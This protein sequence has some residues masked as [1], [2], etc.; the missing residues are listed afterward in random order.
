MDLEEYLG[1]FNSAVGAT[2]QV[3][4]NYT[5]GAFLDVVAERLADAQEVTDLL[6]SHFEGIGSGGRK[7]RLDGVVVDEA[8]GSL[9]VLV[10]DHR[11]NED[12]GRLTTTDAKKLFQAV[13]AF[14]E[15][16]V[17][18]RLEASLEES[19]E[20]Y[21]TASMLRRVVPTA[22]RIRFY[23]AT[24]ALMSD[25]IRD[26]PPSRFG[27]TTVTYHIWD[28]AR[29]LQAHQAVNGRED[30]VID[31][32]EWIPAGLA[33]L[34]GGP[35]QDGFQ[36][37]LAVLPGEVLAKIFGKYGSRLLEGNVRSFLSARGKVNKALRGTLAQS[38]HLFLAY[39]NGLTSTATSVTFS[40]DGG[41]PRINS[42]TDLQIVNGGQTT[43]SLAA[44]LKEPGGGSLDG[45]YVQMKLVVVDPEKYEV[46]VPDI[47]RF[48]NSQNRINEADFFANS[49]FHRRLEDLS[50]RLLAPASIGTQVQTRWFYERAR[51]QYLNEKVKGSTADRRKFE[52]QHPRS[53]VLTKTDVAKYQFSWEG[54]PHDVSL[55]AQKN[56][57]KFADVAIALWESRPDEVNEVYFK[58][59]VAK[60]IVFRSVHKR[61]AAQPWYES[62]YLANLTTYTVAKLAFNIASGVPG[63]SLNFAD[64]WAQQSVSDALLEEVD[65]ISLQIFGI[66]TSPKRG[67]QNVTEW[68]KKLDCWTQVKAIPATVGARLEA[69]LVSTEMSAEL[70]AEARSMQKVD[71]GIEAQ[72]RVL[73]VPKS[74]WL[75]IKNAPDSRMLL[76]PMDIAVMRFV[77]GEL[78]GAIPEGHQVQRLL[79]V[80]EKAREYG[81]IPRN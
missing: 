34:P 55:G 19:S 33:C 17:S 69:E 45:V 38:P 65:T 35:T 70:K 78:P 50:R 6:P 37:Y 68:A 56:F 40:A 29:F 24:N 60:A 59:L 44:F 4:G 9:V 73:A 80:L 39:N 36:T 26:F 49:Q 30:I 7:V 13:Q 48:A 52:A 77:T 51:G 3:E 27:N 32:T 46:L 54:R 61:I 57:L 42:I 47:A 28:I 25:R 31:V 43:A 21:R 10:G 81:V 23:L 41:L 79:G 8:D 2:A 18:G 64:I 11:Q 22:T 58:T 62:G 71:S 53:Q 16:A 72:M 74:S 20:G 15:D 1:D 76:S 75:A 67:T 66:L 63:R 14:I 5:F 12:D